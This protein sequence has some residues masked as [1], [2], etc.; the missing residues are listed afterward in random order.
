MK[1]KKKSAEYSHFILT[2]FNNGIYDREDAVEWMRDRMEL[3]KKTKESV[4]SQQGDFKWVLSFDEGTPESDLKKVFTDDRMILTFKDIREAFEDIEVKTEWVITSRMDNDDV[5]FPG[6]VLQIQ[7]FFE[8]KIKVIDIDY[9]QLDLKTGD[10]FTSGNAHKN[11]RTR[12][13]VTGPFLSL[14]EPATRIMTCYSRPHNKL[15]DGYPSTDGLVRID[16]MKIKQPQAYMVIHGENMA[17]K[18]T[19]FKL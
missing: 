15:L 3:F 8:P 1:D 17:N 6:A 18:I 7:K 10:K 11:Q 14:I 12:N 16:G 9:L 13:G 4:L 2:R 19:G 5:Y